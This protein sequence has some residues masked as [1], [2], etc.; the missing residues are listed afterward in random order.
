MYFKWCILHTY[1]LKECIMIFIIYDICHITFTLIL[2]HSW[3]VTKVIIYEIRT[4]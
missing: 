3:L 2:T 1:Y 4:V